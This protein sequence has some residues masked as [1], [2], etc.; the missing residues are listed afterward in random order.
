M[1]VVLHLLFPCQFDKF[2]VG[3]IDAKDNES[4]ETLR[5]LQTWKDIE[6]SRIWGPFYKAAEHENYDD[7]LGMSDVFCHV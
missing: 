7:L 4:S 1:L 6:A 2:N 5:V 3:K